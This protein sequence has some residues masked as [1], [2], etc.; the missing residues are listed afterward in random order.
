MS[1]KF[2]AKKF[3]ML[4]TAL[5]VIAA[6][7]GLAAFASGITGDNAVKVNI[8]VTLQGGAGMT[9]AGG[10]DAVIY[11]DGTSMTASAEA[12]PGDSYDIEL[13]LINNSEINQPQRISILAPDGFRF[14]NATAASAVNVIGVA[15]EDAH[16]FVYT[17]DSDAAGHTTFD[18]MQ[19]Q[20]DVLPQVVPGFY[21]ISLSTEGL[22][23][24]TDF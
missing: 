9:N 19:L 11:N 24:T 16:H 2:A 8:P 15:Q 12:Y 20:V 21:S 18:R 17:V 23:T 3:S 5:L 7:G 1:I 14:S 22:A 6:A 4:G 10:N 13:V